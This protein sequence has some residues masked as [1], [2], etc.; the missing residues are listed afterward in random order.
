MLFAKICSV[1][2]L[3]LTFCLM[4][5][6]A[7]VH[8]TGSSLACPDW[9]LC[10][11]SLMPEMVGGVA[12]E[13]SH[14]LLAATVGMFTILLVMATGSKRSQDGRTFVLSCLALAFV[15]F[16]GLLGGLT[17]IYQLPTAVSTA[18]LALSMIFF[19]LILWITLRLFFKINF[20]YIEIKRDLLLKRY[21]NFVL[22]AIYLQ[23][24]L[25]ALVR[26]TGSA[27]ACPD[28]PFCYGSLWP[29]ALNA[30]GQLH[31]AHRIFGVISALLIISTAIII[32]KSDPE[33]RIM[34]FLSFNACLLVMTQIIL[35]ALNVISGFAIPIA[36]AHLAVAILILASMLSLCYFR[37]Y[38]E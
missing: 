1:L 2:L 34:G 31:M 7:F 36:I 26:H 16:Q 6:G 37:S 13:H 18:H 8:V 11:G 38:R 27:S 28:I 4:L 5:L 20:Q 15:I 25:G 10:F 9:P 29:S 23:I 35:G 33:N 14:R 32:K 21:L 19:A 22:G 3:I 24:V 30:M 17:V 12:I